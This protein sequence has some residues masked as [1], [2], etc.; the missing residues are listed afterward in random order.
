[1]LNSAIYPPWRILATRAHDRAPGT[2]LIHPKFLIPLPSL[3]QRA[4]IPILRQSWQSFDRGMVCI[5]PASSIDPRRDSNR[6]CA[7]AGRLRSRIPGPSVPGDKPPSGRRSHPSSSPHGFDCTD[8]FVN[9]STTEFVREAG[10]LQIG[11]ERLSALTGRIYETRAVLAQ[12]F[13][14]CARITTVFGASAL[15]AWIESS[16]RPICPEVRPIPEWH[17]LKYRC[18]DAHPAC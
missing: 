7:A 14:E 2:G 5:E 12:S 6:F 16:V 13:Q 4:S 18:L 9:L 10:M 15:I 1:M 11:F 3:N 17:Q 8:R